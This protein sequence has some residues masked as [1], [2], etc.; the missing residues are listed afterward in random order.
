MTVSQKGTNSQDSGKKILAA[1]L[2][3]IPSAVFAI[4]PIYNIQKPTLFG[5][6]FYYWFETVWLVVCA[7]MFFGAAHLLNGMEVGE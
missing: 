2:I 1:L 6:T 4:T 5:L 3:V 7:V